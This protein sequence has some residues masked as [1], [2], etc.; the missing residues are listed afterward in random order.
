MHGSMLSGSDSVLVERLQVEYHWLIGNNSDELELEGN[1][2]VESVFKRPQREWAVFKELFFS[3]L[4]DSF[5]VLGIV[6]NV[7]KLSEFERHTT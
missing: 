4:R 5:A 7:S 2:S 3:N 6:R 1:I